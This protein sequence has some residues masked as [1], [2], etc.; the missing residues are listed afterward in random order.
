MGTWLRDPISQGVVLGPLPAVAANN[1]RVLQGVG[2]RDVEKVA[3]V[4]ADVLALPVLVVVLVPYIE[5]FAAYDSPMSR[6]CH[7]AMPN[8]M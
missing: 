7:E 4:P 5:A 8:M 2:H 3:A 6:D 1:D